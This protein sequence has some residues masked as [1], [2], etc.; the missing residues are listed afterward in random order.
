MT[1]RH[2]T[3]FRKALGGSHFRFGFFGR[4]GIGQLVE[5]APDKFCVQYQKNPTTAEPP[6]AP[7]QPSAPTAPNQ[8]TGPMFAACGSAGGWRNPPYD[9]DAP[10]TAPSPP[11]RPIPEP[12]TGGTP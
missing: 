7:T 1:A 11:I 6:K 12:P 4:G 5:E 2:V 10:R 8:A 3:R 9:P